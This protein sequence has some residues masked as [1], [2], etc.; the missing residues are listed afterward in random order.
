[1][2]VIDLPGQNEDLVDPEVQQH[3]I[4]DL[5][6]RVHRQKGLILQHPGIQSGSC[7]ISFGCRPPNK[8]MKKKNRILAVASPFLV[9]EL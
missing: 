6:H 7:V 8:I 9:D 5:R 1:M 2:E 4:N 3:R